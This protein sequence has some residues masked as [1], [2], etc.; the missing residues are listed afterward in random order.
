MTQEE[1][2]ALMAGDLDGVAA[3]TDDAQTSDDENLNLE[4]AEEA[5]VESK[6]ADVK[7]DSAE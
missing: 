4:T 7:F 1:L 6:D 2:D 5:S 3:A